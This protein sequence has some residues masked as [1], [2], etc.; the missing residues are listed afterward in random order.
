MLNTQYNF[1]Q[2]QNFKPLKAQNSIQPSFAGNI[3]I[4]KGIKTVLEVKPAQFGEACVDLSLKSLAQKTCNLAKKAVNLKVSDIFSAM[5]NC[6]QAEG[7]YK[8]MS[9]ETTFN[10]LATP[11]KDMA[12]CFLYV[13]ASLNNKKLPEEKRKF[14]ACLDACNGVISVALQVAAGMCLTSPKVIDWV[15]ETFFGQLNKIDPNKFKA[16]KGGIKQ[17][18]SIAVTTIIVKRV[19]SYLISTPAAGK[20]KAAMA[21]KEK[22]DKAK[23]EAGTAPVQTAKTEEPKAE[24]VKQEQKTV[25]TAD[26][27]KLPSGF[28]KLLKK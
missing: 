28:T 19:L 5:G 7:V 3:D 8:A 17:F 6:K 10:M 1:N 12:G 27:S 20:L 2:N 18:A 23:K 14:M 26:Y 21:E 25:A 11:I 13:S 9:D 16:V 24:K 15:S 22:A 4:A